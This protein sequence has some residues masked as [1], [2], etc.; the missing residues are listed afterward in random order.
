MRDLH[1]SL[2]GTSPNGVVVRLADLG[3]VLTAV[4]PVVSSGAAQAVPTDLSV[5]LAQVGATTPNA[6]ALRLV[7]LSS[8]ASWL[9]PLLAL[10]ALLGAVLLSRDRWRGAGRAGWAVLAAGAGIA[11]VGACGAVVAARQD[12]STLHGALVSAAWRQVRVD[13]WDV[14]LVL[15]GAGTVLVVVTVAGTAPALLLTGLPQRLGAL[16][17]RRR[18]PTGQLLQALVLT[19]VGIAVLL[20]PGATLTAL[21]V[22]LGLVL[23]VYGVARVAALAAVSPG[24]EPALRRGGQGASPAGA[25]SQ[26]AGKVWV[27]R[28]RKR[29][30]LTAA[31]VAVL[32]A[33]GLFAFQAAPSGSTV[34]LLGGTACNGSTALCSRPYDS[35]AFP[36]THNAMSA[37]DEPGWF[38]PEQPT[39][40]IN[41]LD[42]GI[43]VVL[44]DSYYGQTTQRGGQIATAQRSLQ[45]AIDTVQ[46]D[47]GPEVVQSALRIRN[48]LVSAAT[49]PVE[50]YLCHGLCEIGA[51]KWEPVMAQLSGWMA[52]HPR[53][54]VT[55]FIQDT[56]DPA[57]TNTVFQQAGLLPYVHVQRPGQ[58]WPTLGQMIDSGQRLVVLMEHQS[59]GSTY[60]YLLDGFHWVQDTPYDNPTLADLSCRPNRGSPTSPLLLLNTWLNNFTTLATDARTVNRESFLLPY[61]QRC[62]SERDHIPNFVAVNFYNLGDVFD[63]VRRLNGLP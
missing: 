35:V 53:E 8:L 5:T 26:P 18:G 40:I 7:H 55:L 39:G 57:D 48:S 15:A 33:A 47:F 16:L 51:T 19:A 37:A 25:R 56:V 32:A 27:A 6:R 17:T 21:T 30:A 41:S 58:P 61:V 62:Q 28:R 14:A 52:T 59:G 54:V 22:L 36:A 31:A 24:R 43:R 4:L 44:I 42:D 1:G 60:P 3:A 34:P 9:L 50:P 20:A 23:A 12:T 63:V 11:A 10:L 29:V 38:L 45:S 13:V 49:G 2:L 46:Q